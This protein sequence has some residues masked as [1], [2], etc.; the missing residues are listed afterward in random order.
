MK[1]RPSQSKALLKTLT[2]RV[3][4]SVTTFLLSLV[5]FGDDP[6]AHQKALG[7]VL[8]E[9]IA[10]MAFYYAHERF[11][12]RIT[13]LRKKPIQ[14]LSPNPPIIVN[15]ERRDIMTQKRVKFIHKHKTLIKRAR[16]ENDHNGVLGK[17]LILKARKEIGYSSNTSSCDIHRTLIMSI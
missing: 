17:T 9:T 10:K 2:W 14:T 7:L 5:F 8:I 15:K 13:L 3:I 6:L 4:A 1:L 12:H 11:W 16:D